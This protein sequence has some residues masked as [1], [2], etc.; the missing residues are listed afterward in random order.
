MTQLEK[1]EMLERDVNNSNLSDDTKLEFILAEVR[2]WSDGNGGVRAIPF[3]DAIRLIRKV[4]IHNMTSA[5]KL[6]ALVE[7]AIENG[8]D[9]Y[10][11]LPLM[12]SW[13][14]H[15]EDPSLAFVPVYKSNLGDAWH[16]NRLLFSKDFA[17]ALFGGIQLLVQ[18]PASRRHSGPPGSCTQ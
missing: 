9:F 15:P 8:W 16:L 1:L 3:S 12:D 11:D 13:T 18:L 6:E 7:K 5:E 17:R 4:L 2:G 14:C 10:G